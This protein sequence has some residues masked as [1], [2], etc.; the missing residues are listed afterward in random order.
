MKDPQQPHSPYFKAYLG[1]PFGTLI[2][3]QLALSPLQLALIFLAAALVVDLVSFILVGDDVIRLSGWK[4]IWAYVVYLYVVFPVVIGA[5]VWISS[6]AAE[7]FF[8]LRQSHVIDASDEEFDTCVKARPG[9]LLTL[10]NHPGWSMASLVVVAALAVYYAF[11]YT[12]GWSAMTVLLRALKVLVLYVPGWYALCQIV[13]RQIVTIWGLRQV[14]RC[15][16]VKPQPLHPDRCGGLRAIN[17]YAVGFTY[18]IAIAGVGIGLM[19]YVTVHRTGALAPDTAAWLGVY[20][21]L[22]LLSF[23]LPP[24]TAHAAMAEAKRKLLMDV[25]RQF[26]QAYAQTTACLDDKA[27]ELKERVERIESLHKLYELTDAFT[28]WPFDTITLRRFALTVAVPLVP[29]LIELVVDIVG[30]TLRSR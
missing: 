15:F 22:A 24:W 12:R 8:G 20:I 27:G 18:I 28:V 21:V 11:I 5:Y 29:L 2:I 23:F 7:L 6:A 13:A 30:V 14:F 19:S 16:E 3:D 1:D 26:Q 10:Y 9:S 4:D 17:N 25:S